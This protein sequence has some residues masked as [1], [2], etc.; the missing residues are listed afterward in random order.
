MGHVCLRAC[1][2]TIQKQQQSAAFQEWLH[3]FR[4]ILFLPRYFSSM[5]GCISNMLSF[6]EF[7]DLAITYEN[8]MVELCVSLFNTGM[9]EH[10][11]R[12]TELNSHF[13]AQNEIQ[14]FCKQKGSQIRAEFDERYR[15][16]SMADQCI[17]NMTCASLPENANAFATV[18]Q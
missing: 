12:E 18:I 7:L 6:L 10:K 1:L 3:C 14:T 11:R 16:A 5:Y 15:E 17:L 2:K 9:T 8:Q 13:S 4:H